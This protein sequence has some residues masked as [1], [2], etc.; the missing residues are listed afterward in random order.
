MV[1]QLAVVGNDNGK[2]QYIDSVLKW[3]V[4]SS[5][6]KDSTEWGQMTCTY[7]TVL[8]TVLIQRTSMKFIFKAPSFKHVQII[9]HVLL[10]VDIV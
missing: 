10:D 9:V 5:D 4:L 3:K 2:W 8:V 1:I 7:S 6:V